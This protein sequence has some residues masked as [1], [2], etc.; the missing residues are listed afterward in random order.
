[1]IRWCQDN[2]GTPDFAFEHH[3]VYN[4]GLN[5]SGRQSVLPLPDGPFSLI[6]AWSVFTHLIEEQAVHY[7]NEAARVLRPDG[8]LN[9]TWFLF[10][11]DGFPMMQEFQN[12]LYINVDDPTNA[13]IFDREW[14]QRRAAEAGLVITYVNPPVIQGFQWTVTFRPVGAGEE[15]AAFPAD[16]A[17]PGRAAPPMMPADAPSIGLG[18]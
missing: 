15:P 9:S 6:N 13:V 10:D 1:M 8:Y 2:L 18:S 17:L 4:R 12:A 3:D 5:P 11:K 7:L 16:T 14:L